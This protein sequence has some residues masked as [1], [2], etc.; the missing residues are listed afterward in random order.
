M[1]RWADMQL[2]LTSYPLSHLEPFECEFVQ[3]GTVDKAPVVYQMWVHFSH[4][5]FTESPEPD[6]DPAFQY[7]AAPGRDIRTFDPTRYALSFWLPELVRS[8][9]GRKCYH[10]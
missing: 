1:T 3:S 7:S 4:H 5:C 10:T 6:D 2:G 9:V 8:L